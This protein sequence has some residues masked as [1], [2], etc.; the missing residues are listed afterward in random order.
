MA[1]EAA[2]VSL[3]KNLGMIEPTARE[4][5]VSSK[6]IRKWI[7]EDASFAQS[8][9]DLRAASLD[10]VESKMMEAIK[11]WKPGAAQLVMF[12]LKTMGRERG[13]TERIDI[14]TKQ[15]GTIIVDFK[16]AV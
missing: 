4:V 12:Y 8:V 9:G 6:T 1:K 13:Y 11:Q 14:Q 15:E 10:F 16:R 5:G 2:L 3:E 7:R